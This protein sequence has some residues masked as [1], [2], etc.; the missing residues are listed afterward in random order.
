MTRLVALVLFLL[1]TT[2]SADGV[3]YD[4]SAWPHWVTTGCQSTRMRVLIRDS[5][6]TAQHRN[7]SDR[8]STLAWGLWVDPYTGTIS[9]N[10]AELDVDH[11]V[12]LGHVHEHGGAAWSTDRKRE[13][14]N[15]LRNRRHLVTTTS[16]ANRQKGD[17]G[18]LGWLPDKGRCEYVKEWAVVKYLWSIEA[19]DAERVKVRAVIEEE[20]S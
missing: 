11:R 3:K 16:R 14:A 6:E 13:Y 2:A 20:C 4:R 19:S 7:P 15:D 1:A 8:C 12:P 5:Q 18:P 9:H 17:R 10:P